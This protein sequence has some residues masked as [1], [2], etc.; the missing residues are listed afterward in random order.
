[1]HFLFHGWQFWKI[2]LIHLTALL[3]FIF[4]TLIYKLS[5]TFPLI[6]FTLFT[7]F[8]FLIRW[9]FEKPLLLIQKALNSDDASI[10][11]TLAK[12]KGKF[13]QIASHIISAS[14]QRKELVSEIS[15]RKR[16]EGILRE[17]EERYRNVV[18]TSPDIILIMDLSANILFGNIRAATL[19]DI[20]ES[21]LVENLRSFLHQ[22]EQDNLKKMIDSVTKLGRIHNVDCIMNRKDGKSFNAE[23]SLSLLKTPTGEPESIMTIIKDV[24]ELKTAEMEKA[25]FEEQ[26]RSIYKMEAIGQ[27]AGGVA[28]DFNN[29]L[30]AISGYADIIIHRY[31]SDEKLKKYASMILSA[32][33]RAADLTGKLLTFSRKSK[34]QIT[35]INVHHILKELTDLLEHTIGKKISIATD[36]QAET[37]MIKGDSSQFQS[38]FMNLSVNARDAMPDGGTLTIRTSN[39]TIDK[40]F[41]KS[42]AY[43]V[44]SGYYLKVEVSDTGTGI[45]KQI[46][47]H[48]F[49]PFFTTKDIGKG[50]GLGLASVYGTVKSHQGYIDVSSEPGKGTTFTLYFPAMRAVP[51]SDSFDRYEMQKG[52]GHILVVDDELF[53]LEATQEMLTWLGYQ[54]SIVNSGEEAIEVVKSQHVDL[55]IADMMMP[56]MNG[57]ETLKKVKQ[58]NPSIK[59]LLSTGYLFE[60]EE[61]AILNEG[62]SKII[63]KPFV[64]AQLAQIIYDTLNC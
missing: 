17:S 11:L 21:V 43:S 42:R 39:Y 1:M 16:I 2:I 64:S 38:A 20:T 56:G 30:G 4:L 7:I 37:P 12:S 60:D 10:V 29:I 47:S 58:Y 3:I 50:T 18:E 53:I 22:T 33:T 27:L 44:A 14:R 36:F 54:V 6:L 40:E 51:D 49:E 5:F 59:A 46:M 26:F 24:T 35:A 32:A 34:L 48:L 57:I 8:Y 31:A 15:E 41:S 23:I 28:H 19:F 55:M 9:Q 61:H 13:G 63:Q 62:F 25:R 52:K 45:D